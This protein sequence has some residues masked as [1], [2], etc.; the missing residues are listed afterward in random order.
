MY[1]ENKVTTVG[2]DAESELLPMPRAL[3]DALIDAWEAADAAD[4]NAVS[5]QLGPISVNTKTTVGKWT[6]LMVA[7]GL[8]A[9]VCRM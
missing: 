1:L 7:C 3:E 8:K 2:E 4:W 9:Q 6:P 5:E